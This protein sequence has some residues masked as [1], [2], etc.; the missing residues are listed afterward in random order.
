VR[1]VTAL[2]KHAGPGAAVLVLLALG[3]ATG[4]HALGQLLAALA[5]ILV[6]AKLIGI[7]FARL[8]LPPVLGELLAGIVL[9]NLGLTGWHGLDFVATDPTVIMLAELG[10]I[11]LLFEV[12]LESDV[13]QMLAVGRAAFIVAVVGVVLP[14]GLGYGVAMLMLPD[15]TWHVHLFV[16]AILAATSVGITA[17][18][19]KD[20]GVVGSVEGRIILGAAVI[21]DVLGLIVLAVVKG[22]ALGASGGQGIGAV[23]VLVIVGKAVGFL[24]VAILIGGRVS[25]LV[26]KV[27]DR[28]YV[29]G[30]LLALALGACFGAAIA[31]E[32]LGM[33]GIIGAFAAG[34]VLDRVAYRP[35]EEKEG[36]GLESL[37]HPIAGM[38]VPVFFVVTGAKVQLA[39][40]ADWSVLALGGLLTLAALVGKQAC[41]LVAGKGLNRWAVGFG[42][43]PRG[44]VG[45]IFAATGAATMLPG[46]QPVITP[47]IYAA[48]I[49]M[50]MITTLVTPPLLTQA[51][52]RGGMRT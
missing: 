2:G 51:V 40:L 19:L 33:A 17:R 7:L 3:G 38:L 45:L 43:I 27:A 1:R 15:S 49:L 25:R 26:F 46:G 30:L 21:D 18:V 32:A 6:L 16:G 31:A 22:I 39:A 29:P 10:V 36:H 41:G 9:G 50:V 24:G 8:S 28:V 5:I 34:M 20:L 47:P 4:G 23:D 52:R 12:G 42:M 35:I 11:I 44:E 48:I 37:V 13:G 14:M